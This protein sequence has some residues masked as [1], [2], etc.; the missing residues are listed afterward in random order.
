M[1]K[2]SYRRN[3]HLC[4]R[5]FLP[6]IETCN[7]RA[8]G[9]VPICVASRNPRQC[10]HSTTVISLL[11]K[12]SGNRKTGNLPARRSLSE[13]THFPESA[14]QAM[15][16][17]VCCRPSGQ[18]G[19]F[20]CCG[21]FRHSPVE[22]PGMRFFPPSLPSFQGAPQPFLFFSCRLAQAHHSFF[23]CSSRKTTQQGRVSAKLARCASLSASRARWAWLLRQSM[24]GNRNASQSSAQPVATSASVK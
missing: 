15:F 8:M 23:A 4:W 1:K 17:G 7:V 12:R 5:Q 2:K 18:C 13:E 11:L 24:S 21:A 14:R 10:Q 9:K 19:C 6:K 22:N 3:L 20:F 16:C